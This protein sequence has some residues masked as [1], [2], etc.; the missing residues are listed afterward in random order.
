M[1]PWWMFWSSCLEALRL[2]PDFHDAKTNLD[3]ALAEQARG[4][5]QEQSG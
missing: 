2:Q 4:R 5:A 3:A 1:K